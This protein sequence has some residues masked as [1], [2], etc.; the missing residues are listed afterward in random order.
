MIWL[1]KTLLSLLLSVWMLLCTIIGIPFK[2]LY[3]HGEF[4]EYDAKP[5][6]A[7]TIRIMSFNVRCDDI[8]GEQRDQR[9]QDIADDPPAARIAFFLSSFRPVRLIPV[10]LPEE[11]GMP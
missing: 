10:C 6:A 11:C 7:D 2:D 4:P 5:K 1:L 9:R 3:D 8:N